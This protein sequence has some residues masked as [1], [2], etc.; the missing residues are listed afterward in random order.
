MKLAKFVMGFRHWAPKVGPKHEHTGMELVYHV[1]GEGET[2]IYGAG[3]ETFSDDTVLIYWPE[4]PHDQSASQAGEDACSLLDVGG[5]DWLP[6]GRRHL[7]IP[8]LGDNYLRQELLRFANTPAPMS[9]RQAQSLGLRATALL[10]DL[11]ARANTAPDGGE[12]PAARQVELARQYVMRNYRTLSSL[13]EVA[14]HVGLSLDYL[15]HRFQECHQVSLKQFLIDVRVN[16][17]E[18]LLRHTPV[19]QKQIAEDCGFANVRYFS[20]SFKRATG[21]TPGQFRGR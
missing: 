4:V 13:R 1:G 3:K 19:P 12:A 16:Q 8:R 11:L 21:M 14:A 20:A 6:K 15:R 18:H 17:A 9:E 2:T 5:V 7:K 10:L